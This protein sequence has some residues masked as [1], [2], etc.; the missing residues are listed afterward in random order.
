M[1][2]VLPHGSQVAEIDHAKKQMVI[3]FD[4]DTEEDPEVLWEA[5]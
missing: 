4:K 1:D 2:T 3:Y 5:G